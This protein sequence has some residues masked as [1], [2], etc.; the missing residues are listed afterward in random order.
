MRVAISRGIE[1]VLDEGHARDLLAQAM[2]SGDEIVIRCRVMT[3][4]QVNKFEQ[5][6]V[7]Y[8]E[9]LDR[10]KEIDALEIKQ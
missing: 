2:A 6:L 5:G 1:S 7:R 4:E 9:K 3:D 8:H 10:L